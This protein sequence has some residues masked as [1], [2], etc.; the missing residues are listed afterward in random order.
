M[1]KPVFSQQSMSH[2]D[3]WH[4]ASHWI[5]DLHSLHARCAWAELKRPRVTQVHSY[6]GH[7]SFSTYHTLHA[8][9]SPWK[10]GTCLEVPLEPRQGRVL[11]CIW[12]V[13]HL[14]SCIFHCVCVCVYG[15]VG[16]PSRLCAAL[17][18]ACY[19]R[20]TLHV[21]TLQ[22]CVFCCIFTPFLHMS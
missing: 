13:V 21:C 7:A 14:A 6:H 19:D 22:G 12:H 2:R 15:A 1:V 9:G 18:L 3:P 8:C 10:R 4:R 17:H 11:L 20:K 16:T 5:G